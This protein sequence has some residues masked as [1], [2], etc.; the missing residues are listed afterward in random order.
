[1]PM[2][3]GLWR[4]LFSLKTTLLL[5]SL[6]GFFF[7]LGTIFPQGE[8]LARYAQA[9]GKYIFFVKH[10]GLLH[11]FTSPTFLFIVFLFFLNLFLCSYQRLKGL[12]SRRPRPAFQRAELL[13]EP[14]SRALFLRLHS[15]G[16]ALQVETALKR[17]GFRRLRF[18]YQSPQ[19]QRFV[20]QRGLPLKE[21]SVFSHFC[22]LLCLIGFVVT[23]LGAHEG[24]VTL[25]PGQSK[26]LN[27]LELRSF[28]PFGPRVNGLSLKLEEFL[29]EYS[30][31]AKLDYP[32][33]PH[34]RLKR[35]LDIGKPL[36]TFLPKPAPEGMTVKDYISRLVAL[37]GE[38]L[39]QKVDLEVNKP[40]TLGGVIFYQMAYEQSFDLLINGHPSLQGLSPEKEFTLPDHEGTFSIDYLT[41]GVLYL[42]DGRKEE[43]VASGPLYHQRANASEGS[44][45]TKVGMLTA[46]SPFELNGLSLTLTAFKQ[47][48]VLSY[49][50]DPGLGLLY[51]A[52][53]LFF[54]AMTVRSWGRRYTLRCLVEEEEGHGMVSFALASM[55][56]TAKPEAVMERLEKALK[57]EAIFAKR[58]QWDEE[59]RVL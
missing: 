58:R 53:S 56:L 5:L 25:Y 20:A 47:G 40:L 46:E 7:I 23:H 6:L 26:D 28:G 24:E 37:K 19:C 44:K 14:F 49:R 33:D 10:L 50:Y 30:E 18:H 11:L 34:E 8:T 17:A 39:L 29:I 3:R 36:V 35:A 15:P 32:K 4:K 2:L 55:G 1:M 54:I 42:A 13:R 51:L 43:V 27:T 9:G 22:I 21:I 41:T 38:R 52:S 59:R 31:H 57:E 48:S 45:P 16:G 12:L